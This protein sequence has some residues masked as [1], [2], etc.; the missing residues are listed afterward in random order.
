[1]DGQGKFGLQSLVAALFSEILKSE[2]CVD[3][4]T[5]INTKCTVLMNTKIYKNNS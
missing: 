4:G 5:I 2:C 3:L 1:M